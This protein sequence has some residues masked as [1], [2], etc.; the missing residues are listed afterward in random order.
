MNIL[1][2]A[3]RVVGEL[4]PD[5][6]RVPNSEDLWVYDLQSDSVECLAEELVQISGKLQIAA[7]QA[8]GLVLHFGKYC[9]TM[10]L[11]LDRPLIDVIARTQLEVEVY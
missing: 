3:V 9:D 5:W 11:I 10:S 8:E 6:Y 4:S 2:R 7:C 1:I